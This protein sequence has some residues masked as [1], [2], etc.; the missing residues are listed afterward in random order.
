MINVIYYPIS[1]KQPQAVASGGSLGSEEPPPPPPKIDKETSTKRS[2]RM[3][4]SVHW[5]VQKG[6]L[7]QSAWSILI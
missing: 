7:I 1:L 2:T 3:Y 5:N 4:G 6:Q